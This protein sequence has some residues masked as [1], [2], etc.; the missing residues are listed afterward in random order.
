M[1]DIAFIPGITDEQGQENDT[2]SSVPPVSGLEGGETER[3][4]SLPPLLERAIAMA[5]DIERRD[6]ES[7]D[8]DYT[9]HQGRA[10]VSQPVMIENSL[11]W[12]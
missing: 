5:N 3:P 6:R 1:I 8:S 11:G 12:I 2:V 10:D 7:I 4:T 9:N